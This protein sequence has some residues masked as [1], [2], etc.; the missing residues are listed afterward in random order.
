[1]NRKK[2]RKMEKIWH[3]RNLDKETNE[4]KKKEQVARMAQVEKLLKNREA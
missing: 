2:N 1:M 4:V 3:T